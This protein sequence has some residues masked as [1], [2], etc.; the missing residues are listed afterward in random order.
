MLHVFFGWFPP[1]KFGHRALLTF[2]YL[3]L[4]KLPYR[5]EWGTLRAYTLFVQLAR[6]QSDWGPISSW[7]IRISMYVNKSNSKITF[8]LVSCAPRK[9]IQCI[10]QIALD[11]GNHFCGTMLGVRRNCWGRHSPKQGDDS[12]SGNQLRDVLLT[13]LRVM[14]WCFVMNK[15]RITLTRCLYFQLHTNTTI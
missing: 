14:Q 13:L 12:S 5:G 1:E 2:F 7:E 6:A 8:P 3:I 15:V 9:F 11:N 10:H 4:C